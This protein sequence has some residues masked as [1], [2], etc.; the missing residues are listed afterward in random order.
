[1]LF[2]S[3]HPRGFE[4]GFPL[5][6]FYTGQDDDGKKKKKTTT[7]KKNAQQS[8]RFGCARRSSFAGVVVIRCYAEQLQQTKDGK[9]VTM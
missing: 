7:K 4:S 3:S 8:R 5:I 6:L 9:D 2:L 1:V